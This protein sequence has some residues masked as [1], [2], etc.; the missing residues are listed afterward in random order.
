MLV[1]TTPFVLLGAGCEDGRWHVQGECL[2]ED[3]EVVQSAAVQ[4]VL[5]VGSRAPMRVYTYHKV[6]PR[7]LEHGFRRIGASIPYTLP[8][9][10]EDIDVPTFWHVLYI[11]S[12]HTMSYCRVISYQILSCHIISYHIISYHIIPYHIIPFRSYLVIISDHTIAYQS[13]L[14]QQFPVIIL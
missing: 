10:H 8:S 1:P 13:M 5:E 6:N 2:Q 9:G 7:K 14:Y 3:A 12:Y 4:V 11:L